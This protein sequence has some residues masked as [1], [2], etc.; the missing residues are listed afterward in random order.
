MIATLDFEK[1]LGPLHEACEL[2]PGLH[3]IDEIMAAALAR[4]EAASELPG[5]TV[6]RLSRESLLA[7]VRPSLE[8]GPK[9]HPR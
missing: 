3:R 7:G 1:R 2:P 9:P 4:Y 8:T 6:E 5:E